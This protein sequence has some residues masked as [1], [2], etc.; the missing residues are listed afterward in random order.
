MSD[1]W[2]PIIELHQNEKRHRCAVTGQCGI[3]AL[4][5]NTVMHNN[6]FGVFFSDACRQCCGQDLGLTPSA[7]RPDPRHPPG[8]AHRS[9]RRPGHRVRLPPPDLRSQSLPH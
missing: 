1:P 4:H 5:L 2:W 9:R 3:F 7:H 8:H 6:H